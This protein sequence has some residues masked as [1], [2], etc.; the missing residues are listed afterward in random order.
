MMMYLGGGIF[1]NCAVHSVGPLKL[2][3]LKSF[4][5]GEILLNYFFVSFPFFSYFLFLEL[6][7]SGVVST[8][9]IL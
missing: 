8:R 1:S 5:F 2:K 6:P 4:S 7:Y 9:L 3:K